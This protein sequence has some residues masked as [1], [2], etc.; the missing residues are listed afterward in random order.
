MLTVTTIGRVTKDLESQTS[1]KG[2]SYLRF[3]LAVNKGYGDHV[4]TI[5]LQCW[6]Y[7][8]EVNRIQKAGVKKGSMITISG[9]GD[10]VEYDKK[11]GTKGTVLKIQVDRWSYIPVNKVKEEAKEAIPFAQQANKYE[12]RELGANG[13]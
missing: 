7:G 8:E 9:D 4:R 6:I 3:D 2:N 11:D 5:Y 13:L 12:E 1:S 10:L